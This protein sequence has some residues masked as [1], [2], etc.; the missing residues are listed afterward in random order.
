VISDLGSARKLQNGTHTT[1]FM[2]TRPYAHP[3]LLALSITFTSDPNRVR[4]DDVPRSRLKKAF[5]LYAL[6]KNLLRLLELYDPADTSSL[7]PYT[8]KYVKLMACRLLDGRNSDTEHALGL[9][10]AAFS[11]IKYART[12]EVLSDLRKITGE[13]PLHARIPEM[14]RHSVR[15]IQTSSLS[16]TPLSE[17][18]RTLYSHPAVRRLGGISQL[19][20]LNLIYPTATHSRL[21]HVMGTFTNV[22]RYCEALYHDPVNPFFRQ[23]MTED[24][25]NACFVAALCHDLGHYPLAHDIEEASEDM[26]SHE[27]VAVGMLNGRYD[28][29]SAASLRETIQHEWGVPSRRVADI[30]SADPNDLTSSLKDR[31]L[32]T[33]IDGPI[34]ADKIDYLVRDSLT[35]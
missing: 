24:D 9:P 11:E 30:V 2:F 18:L 26:P 34:D 4:T 33:I 5:D 28:F 27:D 6:G 3:G 8:R 31:I 14:D 16:L 7:D 25:L 22:V 20:L 23:V 19:G 15:T 13:Y 1:S 35:G 29:L 21:E 17:R 10:H 12:S 32:H